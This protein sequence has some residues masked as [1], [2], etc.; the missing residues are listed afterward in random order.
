MTYFPAMQYHRRSGL[1]FCVR[2][3][4]RC[5]PRPMVTDKPERTA[6]AV[7]RIST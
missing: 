1:N 6:F 2:D 7:R 5:D 4:N 3:G